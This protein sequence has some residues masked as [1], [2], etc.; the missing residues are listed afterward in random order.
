MGTAPRRRVPTRDVGGD[1]GSSPGRR[2]S[3]LR[4]AE[5]DPV[6]GGLR[7]IRR[8]AV[9]AVVCADGRPSLAPAAS[10]RDMALQSSVG[11]AARGAPAMSE[12]LRTVVRD[13]GAAGYRAGYEAAAEPDACR[14]VPERAGLPPAGARARMRRSCW[15]RPTEVRTCAECTTNSAVS[16]PPPRD[17]GR[18]WERRR[19]GG[20]SGS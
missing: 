1:G 13:M 6:R 2:A 18:P 12:A 7:C 19:S 14:S 11:T 8:E 3:L 10:E 17:G 9:R 4:T 15:S 20:W 16:I 5:R